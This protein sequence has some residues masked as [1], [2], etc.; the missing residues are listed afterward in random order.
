MLGPKHTYVSSFPHRGGT[1][2][3]G[4]WDSV[5]SLFPPSSEEVGN[6]ND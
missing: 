6:T 3:G 1:N 4:E 2:L 5:E